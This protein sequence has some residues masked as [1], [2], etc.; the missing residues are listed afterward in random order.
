MQI[1]KQIAEQSSSYIGY[2][3]LK[4][5]NKRREC[6]IYDLYDS[7][8]KS[9]NLSSRQLMAGMIFLYSLGLLEFSEAKLWLI[10]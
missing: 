5:L 10:K 3:I 9:I 2:L 8:N 1:D 6:T 4:V 7:L